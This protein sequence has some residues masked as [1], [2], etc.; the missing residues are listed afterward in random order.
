[1][2]FDLH[3]QAA[4]WAGLSGTGDA[5][6]ETV[7]GHGGGSSG[8][9][10]APRDLG[11]GSDARVLALVHRHEEDALV[12]ADIDGQRH[13]HVRENDAV[14]ER[15]QQQ[16]GQETLLVRWFNRCTYFND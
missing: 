1:V 14:L 3:A 6:V 8:Q 12:V 5:P 9:P 7:Q 13:R 10:H 4:V 16:I 2:L 15:D 11:N